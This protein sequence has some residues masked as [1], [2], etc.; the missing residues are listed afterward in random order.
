MC[1]LVDTKM[2][3]IS[4]YIYRYMYY[5]YTAIY[6]FIQ[7]RS[8]SLYIYVAYIYIYTYTCVQNDR[9][10]FTCHENDSILY[11]DVYFYTRFV[12]PFRATLRQELLRQLGEWR[13]WTLSVP[14]F[15][16]RS[17]DVHEKS[18]GKNVSFMGI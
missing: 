1:S 7:Y 8:F 17:L 13:R 18:M 14:Q 15:L 5:T 10:T 2:E 9:Y 4:I 16:A 12:S 6:I 3:K 11:I